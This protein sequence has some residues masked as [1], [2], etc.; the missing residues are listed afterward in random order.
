LS[1]LHIDLHLFCTARFYCLTHLFVRIESRL[2][3]TTADT[4]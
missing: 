1:L 2:T 4:V 3:K